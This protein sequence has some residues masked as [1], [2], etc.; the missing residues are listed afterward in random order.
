MTLGLILF[1][2]FFIN[3][4]KMRL[5]TNL[6]KDNFGVANNPEGVGIKPIDYFSLGHFLMRLVSFY[7]ISVALLF[8]LNYV[9]SVNYWW[10]VI[11]CIFAV[12]IIWECIEN[13]TLLR[14]NKEFG[15]RPDSN[16][17]ALFDVIFVIAGGFVMLFVRWLIIDLYF[18]IIIG[19]WI[20]T[21]G[22]IIFGIWR[23]YTHKRSKEIIYFIE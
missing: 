6:K 18:F 3:L 16:I 8:L 22:Y 17:N 12:G 14:L 21:L 10:V 9:N 15:D 11:N 23:H 19:I 4:N 1:L 20:F 7:I 5:K 13:F 2:A